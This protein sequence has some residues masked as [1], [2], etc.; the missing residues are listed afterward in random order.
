MIRIAGLFTAFVLLAGA[1][2]SHAAA[3]DKTINVFAA[4]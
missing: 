3:E 4:A 2:L 1:S